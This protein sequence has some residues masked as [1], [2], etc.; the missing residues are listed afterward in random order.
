MGWFGMAAARWHRPDITQRLLNALQK[1]LQ[2][3]DGSYHLY[4]YVSSIDYTP[5]GVDDLT[6]SAAGVLL[7]HHALPLNH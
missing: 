3:P 4:E 5:G 1:H 2:K 7:L 6:F